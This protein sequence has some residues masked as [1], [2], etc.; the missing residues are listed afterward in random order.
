MADFIE[1]LKNVP[2][3]DIVIV[4]AVALGAHWLSR[5]RIEKMEK[6]L[7]GDDADRYRADKNGVSPFDRP[8]KG[9]EAATEGEDAPGAQ[10]SVDGDALKRAKEGST[11]EPVVTE[12]KRDK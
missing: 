5:R 11:T 9:Y 7:F 1:T 10:S 6:K 12:I 8:P 2:L 3:I 4:L